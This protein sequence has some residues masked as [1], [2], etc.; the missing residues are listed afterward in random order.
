MTAG[1]T[2]QKSR[3]IRAFI[4]SLLLLPAMGC[5]S[6][7]GK[8]IGVWRMDPGSLKSEE[9]E[10]WKRGEPGQNIGAQIEVTRYEFKGD[11]TVEVGTTDYD[12][13][14]PGT[15]ELS[16]Q[17]IVV[18]ML[19]AQKPGDNPVMALSADGSKIHVHQGIGTKYEGEF[20]LV[21]V[22]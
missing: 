19:S 4:V 2:L 3:I 17:K 7:R 5:N 18:A 22:Q 16:G 21:R 6:T 15:W 12:A 14:F 1:A 8:V 20:D 11:G 9:Y 10:A 13:K